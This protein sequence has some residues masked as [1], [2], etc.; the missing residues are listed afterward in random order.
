M[1]DRAA[2]ARRPPTP[3]VEAAFD[4][5]DILRTHVMRPTWHFVLPA[6]IR[7]ML[8]LTAPRVKAGMAYYDRSCELDDRDVRAYQR[9]AGARAAKAA[10]T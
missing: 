10:A 5:G 1:G 6:D 2:G 9:G 4:R 3:S 8:A 7:W